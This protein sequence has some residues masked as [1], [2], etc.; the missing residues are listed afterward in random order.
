LHHKDVVRGDNESSSKLHDIINKNTVQS[1]TERGVLDVE[2]AK[3]SG[4]G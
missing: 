4:N 2:E 1:Q 3:S